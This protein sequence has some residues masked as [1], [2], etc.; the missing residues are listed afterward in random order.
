MIRFRYTAWD[1]SQRVRLDPDELFARLA[2]YMS[3]TDDAA[4]AL[5]A[6]LRDGYQGDSFEVI[7]LDELMAR[8]E[9]A[10]DELFGT[11]NLDHALDETRRH[12]D[13]L[14]EQ[15]QLAAEAIGDTARL[16]RLQGLQD[17]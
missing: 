9:R 16:E 12:L 7:G 15:E 3:Q 2:E 1:G 11:Y 4:A 13:E 8:V 17:P 5:D 6:I 14:L 10:M